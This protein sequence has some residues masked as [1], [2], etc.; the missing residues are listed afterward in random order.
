M[1]EANLRQV[2]FASVVVIANFAAFIFLYGLV[3][4]VAIAWMVPWLYGAGKVL[5]KKL[6]L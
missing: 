1:S 4:D 3:G 5:G 6:G 2:T